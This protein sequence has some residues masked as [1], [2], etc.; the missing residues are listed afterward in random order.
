MVG[1]TATEA[2]AEFEK[3]SGINSWGTSCLSPFRRLPASPSRRRLD[4]VMVARSKSEF[5][6]GG[7]LTVLGLLR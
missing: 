4:E 6:A 2:L 5:A 1:S 3:P 7:K